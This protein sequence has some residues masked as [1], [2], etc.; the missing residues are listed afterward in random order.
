MNSTTSPHKTKPRH[1]IRSA[2]PAAAFVLLLAVSAQAAGAPKPEIPLAVDPDYYQG[3][4]VAPG[5][6]AFSHGGCQY[7]LSKTALASGLPSESFSLLDRVSGRSVLTKPIRREQTGLGEFQVLDFKEADTPGDY[8]IKPATWPAN[9]FGS[10]RMSGNRRPAGRSTSSTP[11][12]VDM[13]LPACTTFATRTQ[14][15][16]LPMETMNTPLSRRPGSKR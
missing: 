4:S 5:R 2:L 14:G 11:S 3:C 7:G 13:Q 6:I 12:V 8:V 16:A 9:R 1:P 15:A 10:A